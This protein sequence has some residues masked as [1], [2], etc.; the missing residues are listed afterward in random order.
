MPKLNKR[1]TNSAYISAWTI[2]QLHNLIWKWTE[3][4]SQP[5]LS[6]TGDII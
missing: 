6:T 5:T 3:A 1:K 4:E 2:W